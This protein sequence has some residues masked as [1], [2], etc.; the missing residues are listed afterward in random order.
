MART[1]SKTKN[2]KSRKTIKRSAKPKA[3]KEKSMKTPPK[4]EAKKAPVKKAPAKDAKGGQDKPPKSMQILL[5]SK[6]PKCGNKMSA[7]SGWVRCSYVKCPYHTPVKTIKGKSLEKSL[8]LGH[9]DAKGGQP[10]VLKAKEPEK[11]AADLHIKSVVEVKTVY[12]VVDHEDIMHEIRM[13]ILDYDNHQDVLIPSMGLLAE[14]VQKMRNKTV[15][16]I[17][18][19]AHAKLPK[20]FVGDVVFTDLDPDQHV[21]SR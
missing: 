4:K 6:C 12:V 11:N 3:T 16:E 15:R 7:A 13:K 10:K 18:V 19:G 8:E 21:Q 14:Q 20:G 2:T 5:K 9:K 17:L 1:N